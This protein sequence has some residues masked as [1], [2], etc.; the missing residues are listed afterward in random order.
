MAEA[1]SDG[2]APPNSPIEVKVRL[3]WKSG[4]NSTI[5]SGVGLEFLDEQG[6]P[7]VFG[8]APLGPVEMKPALDVADWSYLGSTPSSPGTYHARLTLKRLFGDAQPEVVVA[9]KPLFRVSAEVGEPLRSGYVFDDGPDLWL[10]STPADR[11]R[12]I[13]F[14]GSSGELASDPVWSPDGKLLAFTYTDQRDRNALPKTEIRVMSSDGSGMVAV[15]QAKEN[16]EFS[17]PSW[18]ADGVHI[19]F[20]VKKIDNSS[21]ASS[22]HIER[23]TPRGGERTQLIPSGTMARQVTAGGPIVYLHE[24]IDRQAGTVKH[25]ISIAEPDGQESKILVGDTAFPAIYAPR[26]SPDGKWIAFS[27]VDPDM[28]RKQ[29]GDFWTWLLFQPEVA[30]AH[31]APWDIYVVPV[32]GGPTSR[33]TALLDDEPRSTWLDNSTIAFMGIKGINT[34]KVSSEGRPAGNPIQIHRGA[35]HGGLSWHGP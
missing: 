25:G 27:A 33:I 8:G 12:R 29:N 7:A 1:A 22:S 26:P 35:D 14:F 21:A 19:Y 4:D 34:V 28:G 30:E 18:S 6:T 15:V 11:Q 10:L 13:T 31:G 3:P 23:V 16:E 17:Y 5:F 2:T 9:T 24:V 32:E 20:T